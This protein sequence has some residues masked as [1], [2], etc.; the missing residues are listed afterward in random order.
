MDSVAIVFGRRIKALRNARGWTQEELAQAAG[1]DSKHIGALE[2]G[3]KTSSFFAVQRLAQALKVEYYEL[4]IPERRK[5]ESVEKEVTALIH[6][7]SRIDMSKVDEFLRGL[8][9][10][11]KKLDRHPKSE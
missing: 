4:F 11:L 7:R 6:D 3:A 10:A 1:M 5:A 9:S 2:R 8:R